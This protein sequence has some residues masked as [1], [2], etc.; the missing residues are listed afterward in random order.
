MELYRAGAAMDV[1]RW[2]RQD[3][4]Y[5][6][7]RTSPDAEAMRAFARRVFGAAWATEVLGV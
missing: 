5:Q 6:S 7:L 2:D 4:M 1:F 3:A